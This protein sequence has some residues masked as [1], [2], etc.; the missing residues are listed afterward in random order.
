ME[1]IGRRGA[2]ILWAALLCAATVIAAPFII[3][4]FIEINLR[5]EPDI[6]WFPVPAIAVTLLTLRLSERSF[7]PRAAGSSHHLWRSIGISVVISVGLA[8]VALA[9]MYETLQTQHVAL[10]G[11]SVAA[12]NLFKVIKSFTSL[13][14]AAVIEESAFRGF[15]QLRS[16]RALPAPIWPELLADV[17][18]TLTHFARFH[19][20][21]EVPFLLLL[22]VGSG[23]MTTIAQ[24]VRYPALIHL[25]ANGVI[26]AS[27]LYLRS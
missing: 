25:L 3:G 13:L 22:S 27:V 21:G 11:D 20:P 7:Q 24:S 15:L 2:V 19:E 9:F 5:T 17:S 6:P 10:P 26:C 1:S 23:R 12:P 18:F 14:T 16:R 4:A 8:A